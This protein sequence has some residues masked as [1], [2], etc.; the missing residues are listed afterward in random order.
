M[1]KEV[2]KW[3]KIGWYVVIGG[4]VISAIISLIAPDAM[5]KAGQSIGENEAG[6]YN[7]HFNKPLYIGYNVWIIISAI[8]NFY[9]IRKQ[10]QSPILITGLILFLLA[11][12]PIFVK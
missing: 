2:A 6:P 11:V 9:Y 5:M 12:Y 8:V 3:L 10:Q 4:L 1:D 7:I